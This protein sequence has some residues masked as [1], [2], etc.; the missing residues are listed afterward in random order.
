MLM[1]GMMTDA[2]HA[3]SLWLDRLTLRSDLT[4]QEQAAVLSLPGEIET[5]RPNRDF[6]RLGDC[7][8]RACLIVSGLAG[9][10]AQTRGGD[11]QITALHIPGDMADLH[12][13]VLPRAANALQ[14]I[15]EAVIYR[16]PHAALNAAM[17][18]FPSLAKTFWRDCE[19]DAA[20]LS[21][22]ALVMGRLQ[23]KARVAHLLAELSCRFGVGQC[24]DGTSLDWPLTQQHLADATGLTPVHVN[25]MLRMIRE[26]GAAAIKDRRMHVLDWPKL[27]TM[28]NFDDLYLQLH[29]ASPDGG[30]ADR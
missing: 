15:G 2:S 22:W 27:C 1:D 18:E 16:V 6:V 23:A 10:F 7:I 26:E 9:R 20:V 8:D 4:A 30:K 29:K 14:S 24:R 28:S 25:R 19:V 11:R 12:S 13:V 17:R 21:Q 5:I 3:L